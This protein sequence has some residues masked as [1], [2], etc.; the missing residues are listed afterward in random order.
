MGEEDSFSVLMRNAVGKSL[1]MHRG[2][3]LFMN[4]QGQ[5]KPQKVAKGQQSDWALDDRV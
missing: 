2:L 4:Q 1:G 5:Q 3:N